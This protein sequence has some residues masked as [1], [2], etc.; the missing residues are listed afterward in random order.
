MPKN[1]KGGRFFL[2]FSNSVHF[3]IRPPGVDAGP[4]ALHFSSSIP[5][6]LFGASFVPSVKQPNDG[7]VAIAL[8]WPDCVGEGETRED[9]VVQVRAAIADRLARGEILSIHI[10]EA[11][12]TTSPDPWERMA[13]RFADDPHWDEFQ[14]ELRR[15]RE[16]ANRA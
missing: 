5:K 1:K 10:E 8:G 3:G 16:E 11:D 9:A 12:T 14:E 6:H 7:Y 13:G 4:L 15:I 2:P